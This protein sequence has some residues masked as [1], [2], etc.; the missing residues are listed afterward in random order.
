MTGP[1]APSIA[2][3]LLRGDHLPVGNRGYGQLYKSFLPMPEILALL[4]ETVI[5]DLELKNAQVVTFQIIWRRFSTLFGVWVR[6]RNHWLTRA[7]SDKVLIGTHRI[8]RQFPARKF[9]WSLTKHG[10]FSALWVGAFS[11]DHLCAHEP[12][13]P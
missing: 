4:S 1:S 8:A 6:A 5:L 9:R 10:L 13:P 12:E 11:V 7:C 3:Y 2:L